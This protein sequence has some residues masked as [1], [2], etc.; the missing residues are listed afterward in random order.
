VD[1]TMSDQ[2][3]ISLNPNFKRDAT[4][5]VKDKIQ[6]ILSMRC[7]EHNETPRLVNAEGKL[8]FE[9]CC[10]NLDKQVTEAMGR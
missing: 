4:A 5:A 7:A 3:K 2:V 10:E 8:R 1:A 9:T 6:S